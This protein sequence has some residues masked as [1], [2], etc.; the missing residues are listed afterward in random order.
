MQF[1]NF[2]ASLDDKIHPQQIPCN[3]DSYRL[4]LIVNKF[5]VRHKNAVADD[6][7]EQVFHFDHLNLIYLWAVV[8]RPYLV[9]IL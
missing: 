7:I 8:I 4:T 6:I 3:A 1:Y 5:I 9:I 2:T